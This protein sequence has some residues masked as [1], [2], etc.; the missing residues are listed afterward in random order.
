MIADPIIINDNVIIA[1]ALF[2]DCCSISRCATCIFSLPVKEWKIF[3]TA[4][5]KVLVFIPPPVDA[6]DAPTHISI[7]VRK[8]KGVLKPAIS[9]VL[10]PAVRGE[11]QAKKETTSFPKKEGCS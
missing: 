7:I 6:G 3:K 2:T 4:T 11:T 9:T 5:A 10:N 1:N 8:M